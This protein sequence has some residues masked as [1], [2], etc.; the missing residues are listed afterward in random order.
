[1][2]SPQVFVKT[3]IQMKMNTQPV[4]VNQTNQPY[5]PQQPYVQAQSIPK[6]Q[7]GQPQVYV[8]NRGAK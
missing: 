1:M 6:V 3:P 5:Y 8:L 7:V 2:G 4:Y